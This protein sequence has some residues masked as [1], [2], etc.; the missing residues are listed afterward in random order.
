[1]GTVCDIW[2]L[3][4][5]NLKTRKGAQHAD[6]SLEYQDMMSEHLKHSSPLKP[7][8]SGIASGLGA[9][10]TMMCTQAASSVLDAL[11]D[12]RALYAAVNSLSTSLVS[13]AKPAV[14]SLPTQ[15]SDVSTTLA[16]SVRAVSV[17]VCLHGRPYNDS[18]SA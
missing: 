3:D 6:L 17:C 10:L 4:W 5:L 13:T 15:L 18:H 11:P 1:V 9:H 16:P 12:P 7:Q 8:F 14:A 2:P